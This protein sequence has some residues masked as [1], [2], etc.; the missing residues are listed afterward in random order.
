[1]LY[2]AP[3][4]GAVTGAILFALSP[5]PRRP[6]Q[7]VA[8]AVGGYGLMLALFGLSQ[9]FVM[10]LLCLALAGGLDSVSMAMRHTVRQLA[11][12]DDFRGRVGA[13]SA[14]FSAGGPRLGDFQSGVLASFVGARGAMV[15]G[16]AACILMVASSRLWAKS[17]WAYRGEE[18]D[19]PQPADAAKLSHAGQVRTKNDATSVTD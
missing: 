15:I 9:S 16:G 17:L 11:T 10:A 14:V 12:P 13:V 5:M 6:G 8:I 18:S 2:S 19:P 7:M 1:L 3:S 4:A